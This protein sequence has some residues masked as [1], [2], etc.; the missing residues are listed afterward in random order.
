[1]RGPGDE[2]VQDDILHVPAEFGFVKFSLGEG[3]LPEFAHALVKPVFG[4]GERLV[5]SL[6]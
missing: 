3:I 4:L 5:M 6:S 2:S 1:M